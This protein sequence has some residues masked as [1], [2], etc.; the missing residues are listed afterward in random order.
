MKTSSQIFS[1]LLPVVYFLVVLFYVQIFR[2]R[3]KWLEN[4]SSFVLITLMI[5]HLTHIILRG[6]ATGA[7]PLITK[8]DALSFLALLIIGTYLLI[9]LSLNNKATGL[10]VIIL[11]FLIQTS[12]SIFY[13]WDITQLPL[14]NNPIY[15]THVVLTVLGY[16]GICIFSNRY[17]KHSSLF[18]F[19]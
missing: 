18:D 12:S 5:I 9:E 15:I 7:I 14:L 4:K 17:K 1:A 2:A 11:S 8:F 3:N 10:F 13:N 19:S 6:L 16:T